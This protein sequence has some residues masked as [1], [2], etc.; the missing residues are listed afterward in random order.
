MFGRRLKGFSDTKSDTGR[1]STAMGGFPSRASPLLPLRG[2]LVGVFACDLVSGLHVRAHMGTP[3]FVLIAG[4]V[5]I[6]VVF[7]MC[8]LPSREWWVGEF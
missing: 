5:A 2:S 3:R 6:N 7:L 4:R 8:K 1:R